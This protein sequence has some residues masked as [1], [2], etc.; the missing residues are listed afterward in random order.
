MLHLREGSSTRQVRTM[1]AFN[2]IVSI[3]VKLFMVLILTLK[4]IIYRKH[5]CDKVLQH[6]TILILL[7]I[8]PDVEGN[9][10]L[11]H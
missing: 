2:I 6:F 11:D 5:L 1:F 10:F 3:F 9:P 8:C 7:V 4:T